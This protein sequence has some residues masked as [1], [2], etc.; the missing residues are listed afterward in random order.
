[1]IGGSDSSDPTKRGGHGE[2]GGLDFFPADCSLPAK[3]AKHFSLECE[4]QLV[5]H[6]APTFTCNGTRLMLWISISM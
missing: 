1:M 4:E 2:S 6:L 3:Q 5:Q